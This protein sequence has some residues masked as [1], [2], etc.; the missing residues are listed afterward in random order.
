MKNKQRSS[1]N[2]KY[3]IYMWGRQMQMTIPPPGTPE[4]E[5]IEIVK[6]A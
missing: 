1:Q 2:P 4:V 5:K 6:I 3:K